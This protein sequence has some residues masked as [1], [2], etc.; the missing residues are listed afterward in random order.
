MPICTIYKT[1]NGRINVAPE[2]RTFARIHLPPTPTLDIGS[3]NAAR[4]YNAAMGREESLRWVPLEG[5]PPGAEGWALP[6]QGEREA[7][8]KG[9]R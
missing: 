7:D 8:Y 3:R 5:M 9:V 4:Q 6:G 1:G 2:R